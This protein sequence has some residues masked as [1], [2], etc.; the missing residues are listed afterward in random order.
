MEVDNDTACEINNG[1]V[2]DF[3][4]QLQELLNKIR[5]LQC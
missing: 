1:T 3:M 4:G 2:H 5:F